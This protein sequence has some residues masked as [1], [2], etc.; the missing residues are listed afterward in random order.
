[1]TLRR[2]KAGQTR[3]MTLE[4]GKSQTDKAAGAEERRAHTPRFFLHTISWHESR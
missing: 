1:M 3:L 4:E 2:E